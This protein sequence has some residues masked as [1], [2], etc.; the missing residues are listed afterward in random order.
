MLL[1]KTDI[2]LVLEGRKYSSLGNYLARLK[3]AS[4]GIDTTIKLIS[5]IPR[6]C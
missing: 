5:E 2:A 1:S 4:A 3:T 6:K